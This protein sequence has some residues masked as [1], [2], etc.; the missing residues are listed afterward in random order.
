MLALQK[1]EPSQAKVS[2]LRAQISKWR[3]TPGV[4]ISDANAQLLAQALR[5]RDETYLMKSRASPAPEEYQRE[6]R[7]LRREQAKLQKRVE[8]LERR[9]G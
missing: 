6:V 9:A 2:S 1:V 8:D 7:R 5:L 3:N 4:G